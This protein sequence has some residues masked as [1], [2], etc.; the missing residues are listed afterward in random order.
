[1]VEVDAPVVT[2]VNTPVRQAVRAEAKRKD[3]ARK[4]K[5]LS[6]RRAMATDLVESAF[7]VIQDQMEV[8][9]L[10]DDDEP[11]VRP[12]GPSGGADQR[13]VVNA[14]LTALNKLF[15]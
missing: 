13:P 1:M 15:K 10:D 9:E 12:T 8:E 6:Q 5:R 11:T 3:E 14:Y 2:I 4:Q 7:T